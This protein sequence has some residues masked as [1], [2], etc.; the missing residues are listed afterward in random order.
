MST[1]C[2][3]NSFLRMQAAFLAKEIRVEENSANELLWT[4]QIVAAY[5]VRYAMSNICQGLEPMDE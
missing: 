1:F 3:A 2:H 5:L 4:E